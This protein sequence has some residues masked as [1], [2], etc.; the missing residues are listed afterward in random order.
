MWMH[1]VIWDPIQHL[2]FWIDIKHYLQSQGFHFM[3]LA[4]RS[5]IFCHIQQDHKVHRGR[6]IFL[7][8][9]LH[10]LLHRPLQHQPKLPR[11]LQQHPRLLRTLQYP[12][13]LDSIARQPSLFSSMLSDDIIDFDT[14]KALSLHDLDISQIGRALHK[15]MV[16]M[17]ISLNLF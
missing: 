2:I 1:C 6:K 17:S 12:P 16:N 3:T 7:H 4:L 13:T 14:K 9:L 5:I 8:L 10:L 15:A 11:T